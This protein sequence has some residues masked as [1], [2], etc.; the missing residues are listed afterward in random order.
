MFRLRVPA[1]GLF[2]IALLFSAPL[3]ASG[4]KDPAFA[5]LA[6]QIEG[7]R[8]ITNTPLAPDVT[9][10]REPEQK[11][12]FADLRGKVLLLNLWAT[13]CPPCIRE[14]PDLNALQEKF[15]KEDFEILAVATGRQGRQ[16]PR[17]FLDDNELTALTLYSDYPSGL[18][19]AFDNETLPMSLLVDRTGRI[20]GGVVGATDWD[21]PAAVATIRYL[22]ERKSD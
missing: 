5:D 11:V 21:S 20:L 7:F 22:V 19:R 14:M 4:V 6:H 1:V 13:W 2:L 9:F 8:L 12:S 3:S 15:G 18:M 10:L 17:E 16:T